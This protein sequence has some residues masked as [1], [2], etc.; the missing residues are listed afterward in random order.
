MATRFGLYVDRARCSARACSARSQT[1][2][3][4]LTGCSGGRGAPRC[5]SR[6]AC[7]RPSSRSAC[8]PCRPWPPR[9]RRR[10]RRQGPCPH[11][12]RAA[13]SR[14]RRGPCPSLPRH[15]PTHIHCIH[16][17]QA[18]FR[19]QKLE[20]CAKSGR[21]IEMVDSYPNFLP[22]TVAELEALLEAMDI[23]T[24]RHTFL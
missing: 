4:F 12:S 11:R 10:T 7:G 22:N 8:H 9:T 5:G 1:Y 13:P 23:Y 24:T 15:R 19:Q 17:G 20:P 6:G 21:P 2:K 3:E 18:V 14:S 16:T